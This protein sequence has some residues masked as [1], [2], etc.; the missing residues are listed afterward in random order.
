MN[1]SRLI[2]LPAAGAVQQIPTAFTPV[3]VNVTVGNATQAFEWS[4]MA[5][6]SPYMVIK[7]CFTFGT[8]TSFTSNIEM[9]VPGG[10]TATRLTNQISEGTTHL[11]DSGTATNNQ[12]ATLSLMPGG[13]MNFIAT[14]TGVGIDA[15]I[16][17]TWVSN[18]RISINAILSIDEWGV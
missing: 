2:A 6:G 5:D 9:E 4:R 15:T 13:N 16:P 17:F 14:A 1:F 7:G 8:T 12:F 3:W 18:D 11:F 10:F